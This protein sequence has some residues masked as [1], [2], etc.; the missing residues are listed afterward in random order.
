MDIRK[1]A[2]QDDLVIRQVILD[3]AQEKKQVVH[4]TRALNQQVPANLRRKTEDYDILTDNPKKSAREIVRTLKRRLGN[5]FKVVKGKHAG[6]FKVQHGDKTIADYTQKKGKVPSKR[7]LGVKYKEI[8]TIK[9]GTQKLA[10]KKGAE[11][12]REKDIDT[13]GRIEQLEKMERF[14]DRL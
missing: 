11:F 2:S 3:M 4:G 8:K 10:K 7:I 12:R 6:T 9:R 5:N 1:L 13:L 14:F